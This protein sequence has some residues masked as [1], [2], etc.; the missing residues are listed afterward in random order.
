MSEWFVYLIR[1][2]HNALYCGVTNDLERRFSQHAN[3]TG[4]KALKGKGPLT[5]EWSTNVENKSQALKLEYKIKQLSKQ[6]K[7]RLVAGESIALEG[8][9]L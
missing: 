2:R 5:L 3:G 4:A 6:R 9:T 8:L 7:E 1:N